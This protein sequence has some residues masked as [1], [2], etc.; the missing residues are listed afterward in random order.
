MASSQEVSGAMVLRRRCGRVERIYRIQWKMNDGDGLD[1]EQLTLS[2]VA[3]C[4]YALYA[5]M[6][7]SP[8]S[9][10]FSP[11]IPSC[12]NSPIP[13]MQYTTLGLLPNASSG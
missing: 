6:F 7:P 8:Y 11:L 1:L 13:S 12:C 10:C 9:L 4:V 5:Y 2:V 3:S